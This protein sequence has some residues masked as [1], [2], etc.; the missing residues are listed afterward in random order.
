MGKM[1]RLVLDFLE[2]EDEIIKLLELARKAIPTSFALFFDEDMPS[3]VISNF[4]L[5][6]TKDIELIKLTVSA[7]ELDIV[8]FGNVPE[9]TTLTLKLN[10]E[11]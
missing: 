1:K 8:D 2:H 4:L 11:N 9:E 7:I 5:Q 10:N 3:H 6:F